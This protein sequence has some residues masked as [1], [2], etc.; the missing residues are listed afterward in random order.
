[1]TIFGCFRVILWRDLC[2]T[3]NAVGGEVFIVFWVTVIFGC[4][5][6]LWQRRVLWRMH[7]R[8]R[9]DCC[10]RRGG[11]FR[12]GSSQWCVALMFYLKVILNRQALVYFGK[13]VSG[14]VCRYFPLFIYL[15]QSRVKT[16]LSFIYL[17]LETTPFTPKGYVAIGKKK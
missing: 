2:I 9:H 6:E 17:I 5:Q 8:G 1:M 14:G 3:S 12:W 13:Q 16:K 15:F 10:H 4:C 7:P 11:C